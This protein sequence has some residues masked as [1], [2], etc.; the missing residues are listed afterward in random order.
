M[1][2]KLEIVFLRK[3]AARSWGKFYKKDCK[4]FS[5]TF[6]FLGH[7]NSGFIAKYINILNIEGW[8]M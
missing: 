4:R 8:W 3:T 5:D 2:W 7:P 1:F 6:M